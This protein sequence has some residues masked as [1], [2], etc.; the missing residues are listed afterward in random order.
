MRGHLLARHRCNWKPCCNPQ[1]IEPGTGVDNAADHRANGGYQLLE[2]CVH[3][4]PFTPENTYWNERAQQ[5]YCR[6]CLRRNS[7]ETQRRKRARL[8]ENAA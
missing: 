5:R 3:G 8:K 7:R 2:K 1:H 6:T 4:H